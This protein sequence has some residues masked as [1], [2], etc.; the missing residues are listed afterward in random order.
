MTYVTRWLRAKVEHTKRCLDTAGLSM[1]PECECPVT[2]L[3]AAVPGAPRSVR[4][5][6]VVPCFDNHVVGYWED[7][8]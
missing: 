3:P 7:R 8:D 2:P 4:L 6:A 1:G 5:I